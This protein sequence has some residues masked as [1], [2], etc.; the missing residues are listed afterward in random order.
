MTQGW[1]DSWF[2]ELRRVDGRSER[3]TLLRA[4]YRPVVWSWRYWAIAVLLQAAFQAA[5][6]ISVRVAV[7]WLGVP[8]TVAH[9]DLVGIG[10]G[11]GAG[12]V[13]TLWFFRA[14]IVRNV[15]LLLLDRGEPI[16]VTCGYDVRRLSEPR[17]PECGARF[18]PAILD[19]SEYGP[20]T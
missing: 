17:C 5:F 13:M 2:P 9:W 1:S 18:D 6:R 8:G 10:L 15:R 11:G 3:A 20:A 12:G 14:R 19:R 7:G 4:A 16:C